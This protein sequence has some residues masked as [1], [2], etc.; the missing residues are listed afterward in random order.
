MSQPLLQFIFSHLFLFDKTYENFSHVGTGTVTIPFFFIQISSFK[1]FGK[2]VGTSSSYHQQQSCQNQWRSR[3][4][5]TQISS[6]VPSTYLLT[7]LLNC[8][9]DSVQFFSFQPTFLVT[10][11]NEKLCGSLSMDPDPLIKEFDLL[12]YLLRQS[13]MLENC[14]T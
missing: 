6:Q 9:Y 11:K 4:I 2:C 13:V 5:Y 1:P 8:H 7:Y 14:L 10:K 3:G 12:T